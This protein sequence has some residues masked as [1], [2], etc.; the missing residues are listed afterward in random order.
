[1]KLPPKAKPEKCASRDESRP[2]LTTVNLR[3]V[4]PAG[5]VQPATDTSPETFEPG[6]GF[7]E[8]TDS[9]KLVRVPVELEPGDVDGLISVESLQAARKS[10]RH[11]P[12]LSAG[13][14]SADIPGGASYPRPF[15]GQFP[16]VDSLVPAGAWGTKSTTVWEIGF[17]AKLLYELAQGLGSDG[18][19][20]SFQPSPDGTEPNPLRPITVRALRDGDPDAVGI[21]MPIRLT[22]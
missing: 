4:K 10:D 20:I 17:S 12:R 3:V 15:G 7:L 13:E 14:A 1:M 9:Y 19:R 21:L 6:S 22:L 5:D 8:A 18:V 2:V 11:N 16:N